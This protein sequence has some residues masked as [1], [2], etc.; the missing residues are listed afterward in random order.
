MFFSKE[1]YNETALKEVAL[2]E[3]PYKDH[4]I[5]TLKTQGSPKRTIPGSGINSIDRRKPPFSRQLSK[6]RVP[7]PAS[8]LPT[9]QPTTTPPASATGNTGATIPTRQSTPRMGSPPPA[10][11]NSLLRQ[12]HE[13]RQRLQDEACNYRRRI[14]TYKQAQSN[15]AALVSRLQAKV[16]Q[17]KQRCNELEGKMIETIKPP[18]ISPASTSHLTNKPVSLTGPCSL[19]PVTTS[20]PC[21][22]SLDSPP[23]CPGEY[24]HHDDTEDLLR[25]LE[26]EKNRCESLIAQNTAL[27]QQLEESNRTNEALTNDLQKLTNDWANLRDELLA[28]EDEFNQEEQAFNDYY[29]SEHNRLL[30][31]WREV[32]AVKRSFKEMQAAMKAELGRMRVEVNGTNREVSAACNG[33]SFNLKQQNRLS[34]QH[35][36]QLE[37]DSNELKNQIALL[38]G[39]YEN[40]R[41]EINQ[42]DLRL[43]ELMTQIKLLEDRCGVAEGQAIQTTRLNDEIERLNCAL[44]DIAHAVVQDAETSAETTNDDT[45]TAQQHLHLSQA[46][47][48]GAPKSPRR[49]STRSLQAF[50]EGT[51][52]AVQAALHKYQLSLHD[53]QVKWQSTNENL[54]T[55]RKQLESAENAKE[56]LTAK[57]SQLT[58]KLDSS[59]AQLSELYKERESLQRTLDSLRAEKQNVERGRAELNAVVDNLSC[60]YEKLQLSHGKLQKHIDMLEEDK[61]ALELEIQRIL[62]DKDIADMNLRAEEDRNSRLREETISLREELNKLY[63]NRDLLEQQRLESENLINLLEKQKADLEFDVDKLL[64]EKSE[65]QNRLD[66]MSCCNDSA[67]DELKQLKDNLSEVECERNK[68]RC[69]TNDQATDIA[70]LKKELISAEQTRLDLESEKLALTEK[71]KIIEI[72]KEKVEQ[73]LACVTRDRGDLHNQLTALNRKKESISEELMR[74]RQRLEQ[75]NECN[76]RLNRNLEELVKE[77]EERQIIIEGHEKE[78]QR[79][80]ELLA[81]LRSEKESLEA[82]LFD[83][84]TTLEAT[85]E[86]RSQLERDVQDLLIKEEGLKNQV[87]RLQKEL[88]SANRRAQEMKV[89]LTNAARAQENDFLQKIANLKAL[90]DE[91]SRKLNEEKEI[92]RSSLEKRMQQSLQALQGAKDE[93]IDKLQER[94]EGLQNHLETMA[95]QHEDSMIRAENEKQQAL[96]IAARDK[97]AL[98]EKLEGVTRELKNEQDILERCRRDGAARDEKGRNLVL[99]LKDEIALI[100]AK[101][102][103]TKGHL[104]E[105]V[106]K[107]E[108][109]LS[110]MKEERDGACRQIDELKMEIRLKEDKIESLNQQLQDTIRKLREA[111]NSLDGVRRDLMD[112]RR[113]LADSNIE[114]DK[115][116]ASNRELRDHVKQVEASKREQARTLE[117]AL[118]K[119]SS[120]ED[121]RNSLENEKT[122]LQ[123]LL[124]ETDHNLNKTTQDLNCCKNHL[125]KLQMDNTQKDVV[126]KELQSRLCNETEERERIA[127]ELNQAKKQLADL[128]ANLC[129]TRQELARARCQTNQDEHRW[130]QTQQELTT[131]IEEGRGREKRLEDQ[132][133]NLEVCLADATQQI[134]ELKAR[135]G[136]AEG[137]VRALD[138]QLAATEAYKKDAEN[139]LNSIGHTLRR[140]A[141]IQFD[142]SVNLSY[143]LT[144]PSRRYSPVRSTCPHDYDNRSVSG[145]PDG[146][147]IDVDPEMIRKGVRSLMHQIAQIEREKDDFKMQLCTAKKQLQEACEQQIRCD[148]KTSKL[149]QMLRNLQDEK[150]NLEAQL[151]MTKSSLHSTEEALKEKTEEAA[152]LREKATS[153]EMQLATSG[154]EKS[155]VEDRLEKC[156]Q[157][158]QKLESEKRQ[159]QEELARTE[160]R[161]SKLDLQRVALEGDIT[162]LQMALQEKDCTIRGLQ[163]RLD[164]LTRTSAQ[165]EDRCTSLKTTLDQL[166]D[167]LQKAALVETELRG[168]IAGLNKEKAEQGH[169]VQ[170]GQDK[171]KQLQKNLQAI[172]NEKKI[173]AER[174]DA[175]QNNQNEL[176]RNQQAQQDLAQRLQQQVADLEVQ[177][178]SLESQLR[179]AKWNQ[180]NADTGGQGGNDGDLSRQLLAAQ[181]EK[182][183]LK[184]KLEALK[185]KVKDME[186]RPS[187]FSGN[188]KFDRSEKGVYGLDGSMDSNRLETESYLR[189]G[190]YN[191]GLDH[192]LIEQEN[193]DLRMKVR[194]LETQL[195]EKEAELARVKARAIE[196]S[197][198]LGGESDRYRSAQMQAEKLLDAREQAHKQQV[199]RL[200]NQISMLREQLAQENK[201]RQQYI[202][203]SSRAN[204]EMAHLRHALGD[205]LRHVSQD[206]LD[207]AL[208]E[209]ETRR[210]DCAVSMSLPPSSCHDYDHCTSPRK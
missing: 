94:I 113:T 38:K 12:N 124:K 115:Y 99:Q 7:E 203:R 165:L 171:M 72:E 143:R 209:N 179:I 29:N 183:E 48:M 24:V 61:K 39:Q 84:N 111:E 101:G 19:P 168:E 79:L 51:I 23:P 62:K 60:D 153:L 130:H 136:G 50:A 110:S 137:R 133:H 187:K 141:G 47:V 3:V 162:R 4:R 173:L 52:S 33:V 59:N 152:Q 200:E 205:S 21:Q 13:L 98:A 156:R 40:A 53:L 170:A 185:E 109:Q 25:N 69:Q 119:I 177:K 44:R 154:E 15:Q 129:A 126:E 70:S 197:K 34:E 125:H 85:E 6:T 67:N 73:E 147:P 118:Q 105:E 146:P 28:K 128:D 107:Y 35:Q 176:R 91:N 56:F 161:A 54:L 30:K 157:N 78:M 100:R 43:Q 65:L 167:R 71:I 135:L 160:G 188:V 164:T 166:K 8:T 97:Q 86:K 96:L 5:S 134:Q 82:V 31:M 89:Q 184:S 132:K 22:G 144:S 117:E 186:D 182:S 9:Y 172:E 26:D 36:N 189:Q 90:N 95:Q 2:N 42:R 131:R 37:R 80:Q 155:Q 45:P 151:N 55:T 77:N 58:E 114:R 199:L 93:E 208:L 198:S 127:C 63:L 14:D 112:T 181:R 27:R 194:R 11:P 66:K 190:N 41:H 120:L 76:N 204:R 196:N 121:T 108:I 163:E 49:G 191:C 1:R 88:D 16:M 158:G 195:A 145:C 106:S 193:R 138:E 104:E 18:P 123:T 92:I 122:R 150:A 116:A 57:V 20:I 174:L 74:T 103:E 149:Q 192:A 142:G 175:A 139:K 68:L 64:M 102:E 206:P 83:T 180:E 140:I 87:A 81:S 207:P 148:N 46:G 201:R 75:A 202:L 169:C 32:V 210:L 178:S 17:Y 159:L 10:D